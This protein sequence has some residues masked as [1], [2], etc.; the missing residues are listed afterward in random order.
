MDSPEYDPSVAIA[1]VPGR[2][3]RALPPELE[4][5]GAILDREPVRH[6]EATAR[7]QLVIDVGV[8]RSID[9]PDSSFE[10]EVIGRILPDDQ[11]GT[12]IG[13]VT[14]CPERPRLE[15]A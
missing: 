5:E 4:E 3:H 11:A 8:M 13:I 15:P 2:E 7:A 12:V 9:E 14:R 6:R 10:P 1:A